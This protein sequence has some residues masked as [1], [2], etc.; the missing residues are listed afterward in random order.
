MQETEDKKL[1]LHNAASFLRPQG[2]LE[3]GSL[4]PL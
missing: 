1:V 3:C 4:L 2:A